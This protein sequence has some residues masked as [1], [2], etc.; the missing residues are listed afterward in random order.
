[1]VVVGVDNISQQADS[2]VWG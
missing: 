2:Q 1:M